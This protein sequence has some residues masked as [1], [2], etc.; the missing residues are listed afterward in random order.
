VKIT[1]Q[2]QTNQNQMKTFLV[3]FSIY[4]LA[5]AVGV[6]VTTD[7]LEAKTQ[8]DCFNSGNP[9]SSACLYLSSRGK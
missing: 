9:Y 2:N 5:I 7:A 8:A 6:K 4:V 3:T 1:E